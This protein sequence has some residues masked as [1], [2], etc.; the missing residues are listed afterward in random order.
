M[1]GAAAIRKPK[2]FMRVITCRAGHSRGDAM[3][4]AA[5]SLEMDYVKVLQNIVEK[6][7]REP[8]DDNS[9][10]KFAEIETTAAFRIHEPPAILRMVTFSTRPGMAVKSIYADQMS[11]TCTLA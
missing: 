9:D 7:E 1:R 4:S 5:R 11:S 3:R 6:E 2:N 10:D 8:E